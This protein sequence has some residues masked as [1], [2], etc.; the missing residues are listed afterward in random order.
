MKDQKRRSLIT[1]NSRRQACPD[2][3]MSGYVKCLP[4][5]EHPHLKNPPDDPSITVLLDLD[6][7]KAKKSPLDTL[8][9]QNWT[10]HLQETLP[11]FAVDVPYPCSRYNNQ[12]MAHI[13]P[14]S[15]AGG[16]TRC[17]G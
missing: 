16:L 15:L 7:D 1:T 9:L 3:I 13:G 6:P 17:L 2:C 10:R 5:P 4:R 11:S 8:A 14:S 12:N